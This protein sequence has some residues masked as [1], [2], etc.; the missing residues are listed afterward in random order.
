MRFL[1]AFA[2]IG[3]AAALAGC[4]QIA[5]LQPVAGDKITSV[6]IATSDVL[7]SNNISMRVWPTCDIAGETYTCTGTT[8]SG[9]TVTSSATGTPLAIVVKLGNR[10]LYQGPLQDV[11]DSAGRTR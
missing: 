10:T 3:A 5:E 11:I 1:G 2:A 6:Q 4:S 9:Q 7:T 8:A